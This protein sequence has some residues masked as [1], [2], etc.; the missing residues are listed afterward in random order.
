M[1]KVLSL[2][3]IMILLISGMFVFTGCGKNDN[4][5]DEKKQD[6]SAVAGT[7]TGKYTKFVGDPD[8]AKVEDEEFSLELN[9]DGTGKHNRDDY[10]F[11]VTW[12]LDGDKFKMSETFIGDPIEYTGTLKDGKLDI[13]NGDP[14]N[15]LTCEYVYEK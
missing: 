12:S 7:Y 11:K 13:F 1:K 14:N 10:S 3:L 4:K 15:D 5:K 2:T 9:A 6:L 8:T